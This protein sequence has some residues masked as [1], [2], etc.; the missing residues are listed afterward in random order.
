MK[1][2]VFSLLLAVCL[3]LCLPVF[4]A[5][6]ESIADAAFSGLAVEENGALLV[7]D[8]WNK[9]IWRVDGDAATRFA[10]AIP[11]AD[12]SGEPRGVYHDGKADKAYFAEPWDIAPFLKGYAVSDAAANVIRYIEDGA[13]YTLV[14][15]GKTS[16]TNGTDRV[17]AF[18]RPTGLAVDDGGILYV[19]D[20]GNGA[21]RRV[22]TDGKV[23]TWAEG[24]AEPMGIC[25]ADGALY[26]AETGRNRILRITDGT[27][28]VFAGVSETAEDAG[29]YYGGYADGPA[30]SARFDHPRGV[31]VGSDGTVYVADTLNRAVRT[32]R[33]GRVYTLAKGGAGLSLPVSPSGATVRGDQLYVTDAFAGGVLTLSLET[34]SYGDMPDGAWYASAVL[35]AAQRGLVN[36]TGEHTFSPETA[37]TRAMFVTMLSRLHRSTDGTAVIDGSGSFGDVAADDWYGAAAR[38]AIDNGIVKGMDGLFYPEMEISREQIATM[39]YRY[40]AGQ[41]YE[42]AIAEE[43]DGFSDVSEISGWALEAMRWAVNAGV[44]RG[45]EGRLRP[46]D[47]ATRAETVTMLLNFMDACALLISKRNE[48]LP[49]LINGERPVAARITRRTAK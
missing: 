29:E 18:N 3:L 20:T 46:G 34:I 13:V 24:L 39:L 16:N 12:P 32:V 49:H 33:D 8:T 44:M 21:I 14:G 40:A 41:G 11:A 5:E 47:A 10:G 48:S 38:W 19:A 26:V 15:S 37:V 36:G 1:M 4:A 30:A 35:E 31:A 25:W 7:C 43:P 28:E 17:S 22:T 9:V 27:P 2:K 23:S 42:I 45:S 6:D